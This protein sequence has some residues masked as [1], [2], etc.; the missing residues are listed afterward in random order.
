MAEGFEHLHQLQHAVK[1][2]HT[3][4]KKTHQHPVSDYAIAVAISAGSNSSNA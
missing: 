3:K 4:K 2:S 1:M